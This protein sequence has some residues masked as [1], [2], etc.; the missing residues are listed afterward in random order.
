MPK[1]TNKKWIRT[2]QMVRP[3]DRI[4]MILSPHSLTMLT[5]PFSP[6]SE[7]CPLRNSRAS[8]KRTEASSMIKKRMSWKKDFA[9]SASSVSK[10][11]L[12]LVSS[13]PLQNAILLESPLSCVPVITSSQPLLSLKT[14]ESFPK[15][16]SNKERTARPITP[17]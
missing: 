1:E 17:A 9:P 14:L 10:I 2:L 15:S 7:L 16:K 8:R 13:N 5:E 6:L 3:T 11:H 12:E 4:S